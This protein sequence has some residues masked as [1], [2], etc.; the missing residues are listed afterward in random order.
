MK[1]NIKIIL[2]LLAIFILAF[3]IRGNLLQYNS[4]FEYDQFFHARETMDVLLQGH[5]NN[6]DTLAYYQLGGAPQTVTS[7]VWVLS[8][9]IYQVLFGWNI[10]FNIDV[11]TKLMQLLPCIFGALICIV[12]YFVGKA[13]S[14]GNK[15]V[16]LVTAFVAA[17]TP[18]FVYRT[19][20]GAQIDNSFGFLPFSVGILLLIWA[21]NSDDIKK[22][23]IFSVLSGLCF[24]FMVF[25]WSMYLIVPLI[26]IVFWAYYA[27]SRLSIDKNKQKD[28]LDVI[29]FIIVFGLFNLGCVLTGTNWIAAASMFAFIPIMYIYIVLAVVIIGGSLLIYFRPQLNDEWKNTVFSIIGV[30]FII[31]V[32]AMF[33]FTT[34]N[35][36]TVDRTTTGS[37]VGEESIGHSFFT[38]K[39]NIYNILIPLG[40]ISAVIL[41]WWK[42]NKYEFMALFLAGF[43]LFFAMAWM[44]LKFTFVLG[45]GL[46]FSAIIIAILFYE[47]W[48]LM[49]DKNKLELKIVFVPAIMILLMGVSAGGVFILDYVPSLDADPAL[50]NVIH[51]FNTETPKDSKIINNWGLGHIITYTAGRAVSAD[52]RNYSVLA[53]AQFAR[54]ENDTNVSEVY[55][56]VRDM[57]SDYILVETND[58]YSM[59]SNAFY[60]ANKVS[61][62]IGTEFTKPITNIMDCSLVGPNLVCPNAGTIDV[63]THSTWTTVPYDFYQGTYP[64]FVYTVGTKLYVLN[65]AQNNTNLAKVL[66]NSPDT[67]GY[68]EK[69]FESGAYIVLKVKK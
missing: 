42:R 26:L 40:F 39:Y 21:F 64:L 51:Y 9:G 50:Q 60:I 61:S 69:V 3:G 55:K 17:V 11:F 37:M 4:F 28:L 15:M 49:K 47:L 25:A 32:F 63:A 67:V 23:L 52:N 41:F 24:L 56:M 53:N 27:I 68:Y 33:Y 30:G 2:L 12:L 36:D 8:A 19:M 31:A 6:P 62:M 66:T 44:K 1:E 7:P 35:I 38:Q 10:G 22:R 45:F 46:T 59:Q 54:F 65:A 18:A 29:T 14:N 58:F 43:S 20:A 48:N 5:V 16:G 57:N 13:A 34:L